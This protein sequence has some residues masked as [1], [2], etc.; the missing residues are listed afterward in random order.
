MKRMVFVV[1]ILLL[2]MALSSVQ[3]SLLW[4][5]NFN[6]Q[7][8]VISHGGS[9]K[10]SPEFVS[11]PTGTGMLATYANRAQLDYYYQ[12]TAI[13]PTNGGSVSVVFK[14]TS[15]WDY[16]NNYFLYSMGLHYDFSIWKYW[17]SDVLMFY[18]NGHGIYC[19]IDWSQYVDKWT[20]VSAIWG[21]AAQDK[22]MELWLNG[23]M[24]ANWTPGYEW[25]GPTNQILASVGYWGDW[26]YTDGVIDSVKIYD[27]R[28]TG[29][30]V[31]EPSSLLALVGGL[32]TLGF[33]KRRKRG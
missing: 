5:E 16:N 27:S 24:I 28:V 6:S 32:S 22:G 17:Y 18:C 7:A 14:P 4:E 2:L 30:P 12:P 25:H 26:N 3:A 23:Q 9:F 21:T 33:L 13:P 15:V 20:T 1:A 10:G 11:T 8:D 19:E 31:P 29:G